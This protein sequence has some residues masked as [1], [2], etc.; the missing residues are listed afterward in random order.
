MKKDREPLQID[1]LFI[2]EASRLS[3]GREGKGTY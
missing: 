3:S 1:Y 2:I